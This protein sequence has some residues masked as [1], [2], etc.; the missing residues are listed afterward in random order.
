MDYSA[1][2][3]ETLMWDGSKE[4]PTLADPLSITDLRVWFCKYR[5]LE[6]IGQLTNLRTLV[7]AGYP[8]ADFGPLAHLTSLTYLSVLDFRQVADLEPLRA[9][10]ALQTL[11]LHSPPS[12]DSSSRVIEVGS[13]APIASL[14]SLEHLELFGV[15]PVSESL[16]ELEIAPRL[17]S[18]RV[19]KYP[20][21]EVARF[22]SATGVDDAFAPKPPH[23]DWA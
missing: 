14:P 20:K 19:S 9:F 22:R 11:R 13:L 6:P 18:L 7:I 16:A 1:A 17:R 10:S 5:T 2:V 15:R 3:I 23:A 12:W 4:F 21:D 8:D